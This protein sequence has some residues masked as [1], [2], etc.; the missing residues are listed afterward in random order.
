MGRRIAV[1][2]A[3][4]A[5]AAPAAASAA[6]CPNAHVLPTKSGPAAARQATLC[7]VNAERTSRGMRALKFNGRL[8]KAASSYSRE[9]VAHHFFD[10]VS[11]SGT[12]IVTRLRRVHYITPRISWSIGENIAWGEGSLGTPAEIVD[13]WMNSP[14]HRAN[15]LSPSFREAGVGVAPGLPQGGGQPG[16][17]YTLDFG[18][19]S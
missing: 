5:L 6:D 16:A 13:A 18:R 19:R 9:M 3:A 11:P 12:D 17:T 7:L 10:H 14:G 4:L 15:I 2:I 1:G 8:E